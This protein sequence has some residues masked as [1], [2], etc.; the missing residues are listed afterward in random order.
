MGQRYPRPPKEQLQ[1]EDDDDDDTELRGATRH[2]G[3][4]RTAEANA[5]SVQ[6]DIAEGR[7][8]RIDVMFRALAQRRAA[9]MTSQ[10][11]VDDP[12]EDPYLTAADH[13]NVQEA[14][15]LRPWNPSSVEAG[16]R[17]GRDEDDE[18]DADMRLLLEL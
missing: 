12:V 8:P 14:L 5:M 2:V 15:A 3:R 6:N 4:P 1:E 9:A 10:P 16:T 7:Q 13:V 11:V 18:E 17:R